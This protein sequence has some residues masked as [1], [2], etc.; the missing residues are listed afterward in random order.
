MAVVVGKVVGGTND[1]DIEA[2]HVH[3]LTDASIEHWVFGLGVR[4]DEE[5]KVCLVNA[6]NSRVHQILRSEIATKLGLV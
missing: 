3:G 4:A 5:K 1:R 6:D 2:I